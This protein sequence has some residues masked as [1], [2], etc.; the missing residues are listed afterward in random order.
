MPEL[1]QT[2]LSAVGDLR[3][4]PENPRLPDELDTSDQGE[5][6]RYFLKNYQPVEIAESMAENGYFS[7]EPL[8]VVPG[9]DGPV[10]VEGNRRL[11]ALKL[12][13]SGD[14]RDAVDAPARWRELAQEAA[15]KDLDQVPVI[16]YE[17]RDDLL[18][19][20]G[21]R[22][23][24]GI[25]PWTPEAKARFVTALVTRHN[26]SFSDAAR[27]IGSRADAIRRQ[28]LAYSTLQ[29]T[30]K[31][32]YDVHSAERL[33]G[34]FYRSL[35]SPGVRRHMHIPDP[36]DLSEQTT[37]PV[38]MGAEEKVAEVISWLFGDLEKQEK[39]VIRESRQIDQLGHVLLNA[40]GTQTLRETR[41]LDLALDISGGDPDRMKG[42]LQQARRAL[43][44]A[45]GQAFQFAGDAE[46]IE[47][48]QK[49]DE[50]LR[51]ILT[52]LGASTGNGT[53]SDRASAGG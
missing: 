26:Y 4:D 52:T 51:Q 32:G 30:K 8:L 50:V 19:Y 39:P 15:D 21:F 40:E 46:M 9:D 53:D 16:Q 29:Q 11:S 48:A 5:L 6:L 3:L 7:E 34:F 49:V 44:L 23:V 43:I 42:A 41:D 36:G 37:E 17:S 33:F 24:S 25:A 22:H 45:N 47:V 20:L 14:T 10:V 18:D 27:A 1:R 2:E 35:Q 38:E 28:V 12:L 13:I 31:A